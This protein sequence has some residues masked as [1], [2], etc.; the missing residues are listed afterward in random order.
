MYETARPK[1]QI[2][3]RRFHVA[4]SG[5]LLLDIRDKQQTTGETD[6][7]QFHNEAH[8]LFVFT[9]ETNNKPPMKQ[10][11]CDP[12]TQAHD[13]LLYIRNKEQIA[14]KR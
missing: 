1:L 11:Q 5:P 10:I 14:G 8:D 13:P 3:R 12:M 4:S 9:S 6:P 2:D 7:M